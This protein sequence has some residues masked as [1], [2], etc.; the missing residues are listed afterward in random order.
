MRIEYQGHVQNQTYYT[1][2]G[3]T[4]AALAQD[5]RYFG[6][7]TAPTTGLM[8]AAI[9]V[10]LAGVMVARRARS[11]WRRLLA[12][13]LFTIAV[14]TAAQ[15]IR[16][17]NQPRP[18][19]RASLATTL[20]RLEKLS[21]LTDAWLASNG[22]PPTLKEWRPLAAGLDT[23]GFGQPLRY[24]LPDPNERELLQQDACYSRGGYDRELFSLQ[25]RSGYVIYANGTRGSSSSLDLTDLCNWHLGVD[26]LY[27]TADDTDLLKYLLEK[28]R[29]T[30]TE[31]AHGRT[32]RKG[33]VH[34][35][36]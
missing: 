4:A 33:E 24:K 22:R 1:H 36:H 34:N 6:Q 15:A 2:V 30:G 5:P 13:A 10:L 29:L 7:A 31:Y 12:L 14:G 35:A 25:E 11:S 3:Y 21:A 32:P 19:G 18:N 20:Y 8:G 17:A 27:G 9:L 16:T 23:D 28:T 26:G